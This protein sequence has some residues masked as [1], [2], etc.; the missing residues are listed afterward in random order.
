MLKSR[1]LA[2]GDSN[3]I[4]ECILNCYKDSHYDSFDFM[5]VASRE[6]NRDEDKKILTTEETF[7]LPANYI[8]R[9]F[10]SLRTAKMLTYWGTDENGYFYILR[11]SL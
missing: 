8:S 1:I 7:D 3:S 5:T 11:K 2:P 10:I 4:G 9:S 6:I